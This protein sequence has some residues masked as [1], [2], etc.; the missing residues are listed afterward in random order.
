[1]STQHEDSSLGS[2]TLV[3]GKPHRLAGLVESIWFFDGTAAL[4]ER[5]VPGGGLDLI[6]QLGDR[7]DTFRIVEGEPRGACPPASIGGLLVGPLVIEAPPCP[8]RVLGIRLAP[9]G[10]YALL[11]VPLRELTG[12]TVDLRDILGAEAEWL[13][14]RCAE[15]P[16]DRQRIRLVARWL[17]E[18]LARGSSPDPCITGAAAEIVRTGGRVPIAQLRERLGISRFRLA[19]GFDEQIGVPPKRFARIVRFRAVTLALRAGRPDLAR[20]AVRFGYYDQAHMNREFRHLSGL[21]PG[22]FL[23]A[24]R[25]PEAT[26]LAE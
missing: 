4:R 20:L 8:C 16:A 6:L 12:L 19:A 7:S 5:H 26:S 25:Y 3:H 23:S 10:A 22:E 11:G 15:A 17:E 1:M 18:R 21:A 2:W 13:A 9:A 24:T 14:E